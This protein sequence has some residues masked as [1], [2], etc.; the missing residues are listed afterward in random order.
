MECLGGNGYVEENG[1]AL[2]YREAPVNSIWEG[3][4]NIMALDVFRIL[5]REPDVVEVVFE[6]IEAA[7]GD[8]AHLKAALEQVRGAL[9]E[10]RLIEMRLRGFLEGLATL[11]A[12]TILRAHAPQDVSDAFI[13]ARLWPLPRRTYGQGFGRLDPKAVISR[14][15]PDVI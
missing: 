4:G 11:A 2:L 3:S 9:H 13:A 12:G 8:D 14:V 1:A 10:P 6:D 7:I 5:Q 15:L